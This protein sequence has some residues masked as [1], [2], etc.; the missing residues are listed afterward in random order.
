MSRSLSGILC[1][2]SP[3]LFCISLVSSLNCLRSCHLEVFLLCCPTVN[4]LIPGSHGISFGLLFLVCLYLLHCQIK[5]K[6][7]RNGIFSELAYE[8]LGSELALEQ[9]HTASKCRSCHLPSLW[10]LLTCTEKSEWFGSTV[11]I[12]KGVHRAAHGRCG[13][14]VSAAVV[15]C[16]T[17]C[18]N[19]KSRLKFLPKNFKYYAVVF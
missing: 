19:N 2:R 11:G 4:P 15:F 10:P 7:W 8:K 1:L 17:Q 6:T 14:S 9:A 3:W 18:L 16:F 5:A 12:L 13:A